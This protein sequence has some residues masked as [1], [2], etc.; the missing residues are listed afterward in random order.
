MDFLVEGLREAVRLIANGDHQIID[1]TLRT[2]S[3]S[4]SAVV[5]AVLIGLPI[6]TGL[7]RRRFVGQRLLLV[8]FRAALGV[9]TVF[10]GLLCYGMLARRGPLG[11]LDLLYTPTAIVIGETLLALPI[12]V[13]LTH[14]ALATLDPRIPETAR[15]LGAGPIRRLLTY[16]SEARTGLILAILTAF[17]RC[18]TELGIAMMVGGNIKDR[19]RTL[20]TATALETGKG[21]F[22]V[23]LAMGG[24]L[25]LLATGMTLLVAVL[26]KE[27]RRDA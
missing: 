7:A 4:L 6:A 12:V 11:P 25:L 23:G 18:S 21:E 13:A 24:L 14:G 16:L 3:I 22:A 1:A 9:P 17:T 8:L 27:D 5:L 20:S 10:L 2:L 26:G 19:T 15:T